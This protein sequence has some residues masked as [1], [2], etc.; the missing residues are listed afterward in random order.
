MVLEPQVYTQA[1]VAEELLILV[2]TQDLV[3]ED[4]EEKEHKF[5]LQ[6]QQFIM[7]EAEAVLLSQDLVVAPA[8]VAEVQVAALAQM[9][10]MHKLTQV[11]AVEE[12]HTVHL[13]DQ[14][15]QVEQVDQV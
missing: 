7:P 4:L 11:A 5:Q 13:K 10:L 2:E 1:A 12:I 9:E 6:D 14:A 3:P 15:D 8:K